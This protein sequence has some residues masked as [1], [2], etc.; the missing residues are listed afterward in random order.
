MQVSS[1]M[2]KLTMKFLQQTANPFK[3][4][5]NQNLY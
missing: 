2:T 5:S 1:Q 3:N 4:H